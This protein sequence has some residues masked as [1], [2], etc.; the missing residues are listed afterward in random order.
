MVCHNYILLPWSIFRQPLRRNL[1]ALHV[2]PSK[3][4]T[5]VYLFSNYFLVFPR[6]LGWARRLTRVK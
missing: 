1:L 6:H 4:L 5:R 2:R 3:K